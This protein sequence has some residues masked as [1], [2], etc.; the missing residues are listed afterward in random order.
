M[1]D[2]DIRA[3]DHLDLIV[4]QDGQLIHPAAPVPSHYGQVWV[5]M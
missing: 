5:L 2:D 4:Q 3:P 1:V